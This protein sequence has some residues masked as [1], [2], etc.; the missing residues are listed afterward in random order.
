MNPYQRLRLTPK[1]R[2]CAVRP[3]KSH[4][5]ASR[6]GVGCWTD[7][8]VKSPGIWLAPKH[9]ID[10]V[11]NG[12]GTLNQKQT[13]IWLSM[14]SSVDLANSYIASVIID[15]LTDVHCFADCLIC[16]K[17]LFN[18]FFLCGKNTFQ[19]CEHCLSG[20]LGIP[21]FLI[22][23]HISWCWAWVVSISEPRF[24]VLLSSTGLQS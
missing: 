23:R 21:W 24:I 10:E 19:S 13:E 1:I 16:L 7:G 5:Y 17:P 6:R 15:R 11:V 8:P 9:Q 18:K 4:D 22:H 2:C 20:G 14:K 3:L 12:G